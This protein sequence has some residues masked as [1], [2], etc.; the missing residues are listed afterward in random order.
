MSRASRPGLGA[1]TFLVLIALFVGLTVVLNG[2][3]RGAR[4]DL[5][6]NHQYTLSPG[7]KR[8]L[9]ELKEP[10]RLNFYFTRAVAETV[11]QL[12]IYAA[13]VREVL[14]EIAARSNGRITLRTY[15]PER[16][17]EDEDRAAEAG[18]RAV[19]IGN[20]AEQ[21]YF[22]LAGSN[23]TD[24]HAAIELFEPQ[25]E[26]FLEY[27]VARLIHQLATTKRPV[28]GL[29]SSLPLAAGFDP[30]TRQMRRGSAIY[31]QLSPLFELRT[32]APEATAIPA[33]VDALM[34]VHP[35]GLANATLY[36]IDQYLLK[37]GKILLFV[38][39]DAQ[40]DRSAEMGG[41]PGMGGDRASTLE[42]LLKTW[43]V[44]F[45]PRSAV[46]DLEHALLVGS[47]EGGEPV[48]HLGFMGLGTD[49]LAR[50][51]PITGSL[52]TINFA[53]PGALVARSVPGIQFEPLVTTS[54]Q[55]GLIPSARFAMRADPQMLRED[56]KPTG[57]RYVIAARLSGIFP[58]A[59]P[60]GPPPNT[61]AGN[62]PL[63]KSAAPGNV[64]VVA[65]TDLLAD[66]LWVRSQSVLGQQL[67]EVWASNGDFV[68]N[69]LDNLTGSNDLISIR[70]RATYSRPF[71]RV[72]A[73]RA[74]ADA[75]LRGKEVELEHE[76]SATEQKLVSL[77]RGRQ[78]QAS[79][80]L[81][82]EQTQ[83]LERF[84]AEK[85]R[86]RKDLR[87]VKRTL[88]VEIERLGARIKLI[89]IVLVPLLVAVAAVLFVA[90]RARRRSAA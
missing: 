87:E 90:L 48:R 62:A 68:L 57:Q 72:E 28:V 26:E 25:R 85:L 84:Q 70:G 81:T 53:S 18:L 5:T 51:D 21:L 83:E 43:G 11:P 56:F 13:H 52:E 60:H 40:L 55:S 78:D 50:K 49:S 66:M 82:P 35:K 63:A 74:Q 24:G 80:A 12:R 3:L 47:R 36:A 42:P 9:A 76:L 1:A 59:F 30:E 61:P 33:D 6:E 77:Q 17:S 67:D 4:L 27:D 41:M 16:Y 31:Q 23:S 14:E 38:D 64:I 22:G 44:D 19:P 8:M 89:N 69:S 79:L 86:V 45:D 75:R 73:L 54:A 15:N 34:L 46:G 71:T 39:P 37:G 10:I 20:G 88:D 32:I 7:T 58:T 29:I 65:D 2:A